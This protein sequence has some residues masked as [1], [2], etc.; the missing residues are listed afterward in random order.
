MAHFAELDENNKVLRVIVVNN[1][2][3]LDQN[4]DEDESIGAKFCHDLLGGAKWIQASYN[5]SFRKHFPSEGFTYDQQR[6]VFI[7]PC[8][9]APEDGFVLDEEDLLWKPPLPYPSDGKTYIWSLI[10]KN[11]KEIDGPPLGSVA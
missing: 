3:C 7:P 1:D 10:D 11:W 6:D 9:V 2:C 8:P 5:K 4:G